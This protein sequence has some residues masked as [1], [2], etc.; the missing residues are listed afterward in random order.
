MLLG[1]GVRHRQKLFFLDRWAVNYPSKSPNP[2][3]TRGE[4]EPKIFLLNKKTKK[5][6]LINFFNRYRFVLDTR[7]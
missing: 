1:V 2:I 6:N 3:S 7:T 4:S 5:N